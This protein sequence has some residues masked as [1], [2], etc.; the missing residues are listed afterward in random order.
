MKSKLVLLLFVIT[1]VGCSGLTDKNNGEGNAEENHP[2]AVEYNGVQNTD[3]VDTHGQVE[4]VNELDDF[5]DHVK[6]NVEDEVRIIQYTVEGDPMITDL[7]YDG[8]SISYTHD[9]TRDNFGNGEVT[10][11]RCETITKRTS[12]IETVY[13]LQCNGGNNNILTIRHNTSEQD[14]FAFELKFGPEMQN[15]INTKK[16]AVTYQINQDQ[17]VGIAD[18]QFSVEELN[19]IYKAMVIGNYL[20]E[21]KLSTSCDE[22]SQES[23]EL[24]VWINGAERQ[25]EWAKC[26]TSEDGKQMTKMAEQ[27]VAVLHQNEWFQ[28]AIQ[29]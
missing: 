3:V 11:T 7:V 22:E 16:E 24:I 23:Y 27:I 5:V 8:Q 21:K 19:E 12:N 9:T 28:E 4:N 1:L 20:E 6:A 15:T 25:F 18:F 14:Y 13:Q 17:T 26:D 2:D 10:T 29:N